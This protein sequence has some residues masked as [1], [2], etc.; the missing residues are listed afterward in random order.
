MDVADR[1]EQVM[2]DL[3][4]ETPEVPGQQAAPWREVDRGPS[5]MH[6]PG[7]RRLIGSRQRLRKIR[8]LHAVRELKDYAQ[9]E[10]DHECGDRVEQEHDPP[11]MKQRRDPER[12]AKEERFSTDHLEQPPPARPGNAIPGDS[13]PD[14]VFEVV[15]EVPLG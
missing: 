15:D 3:E 4:V 2:L 11:S 6:G 14:H 8:L 10:T 7:A 12:E 1:G 13:G 5:L 9:G